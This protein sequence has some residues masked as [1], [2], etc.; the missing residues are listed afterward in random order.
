MLETKK[1]RDT[2]SIL[3]PL[4]WIIKAICQEPESDWINP[5]SL[6]KKIADYY[7]ETPQMEISL[8]N[9][10]IK[11]G[12]DVVKLTPKEALLEDNSSIDFKKCLKDIF[13]KDW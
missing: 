2:L 6:L 11:L 1:K 10:P 8:D 7:F 5:R 13:N 9:L 4:T 3:L 12:K